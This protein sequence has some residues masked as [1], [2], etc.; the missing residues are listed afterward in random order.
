MENNPASDNPYRAPQADLQQPPIVATTEPFTSEIAVRF[1][2]ATI[3][4]G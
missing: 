4:A 3:A 2:M 1:G